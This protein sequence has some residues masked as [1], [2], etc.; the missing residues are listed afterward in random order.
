LVLEYRLL[1]GEDEAWLLMEVW[2]TKYWHS[3]DELQ[4]EVYR[5]KKSKVINISLL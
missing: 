1:W 4:I 5:F 2:R 3:L